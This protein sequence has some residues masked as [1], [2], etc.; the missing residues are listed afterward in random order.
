[1]AKAMGNHLE[2]I[3]AEVDVFAYDPD[4]HE[5]V[6]IECKNEAG[7]IGIGSLHKLIYLRN[8]KCKANGK[9]LL[10]DPFDSIGTSI[11]K[12]LRFYPYLRI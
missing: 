6:L 5:V 1:M 11:W 9:V 8:V 2:Q 10:I 12:A 3:V 7:V 4:N